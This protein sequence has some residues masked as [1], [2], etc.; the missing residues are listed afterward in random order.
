MISG[1][2]NSSN[3]VRLAR[4]GSASEYAAGL[5]DTGAAILGNAVE[6][7]CSMSRETEHGKEAVEQLK[8]LKNSLMSHI[9]R[10]RA[11]T[12]ANRAGAKDAADS[13]QRGEN[14]K[15]QLQAGHTEVLK[16]TVPVTCRAGAVKELKRVTGAEF[17]QVQAPSFDEMAGVKKFLA[18][19]TAVQGLFTASVMIPGPLSATVKN[20]A[21]ELYTSNSQSQSSVAGS[22]HAGGAALGLLGIGGFS[23][24]SSVAGQ[25]SSST[26]ARYEKSTV[27]ERVVPVLSELQDRLSQ[28]TVVPAS[29]SKL[30]AR[31]SVE[32]SSGKA[33][34]GGLG[35]VK[36]TSI[37]SQ[38]QSS[39]V[40]LDTVLEPNFASHDNRA[41][42]LLE[43]LEYQP[44]HI[45]LPE[46]SIS[47]FK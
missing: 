32:E 5:K 24:D 28:T 11:S 21:K 6:V 14:P 9:E 34:W 45:R 17:A 25:S 10:Q 36:Y 13:L 20:V 4:E 38:V 7:F 35:S 18:D 30:V 43:T 27:D 47:D 40:R 2:I 22:S 44:E 23:S 1:S 42:R 37:G 31:R 8:D 33:S 3:L 12:A 19:L 29:S 39:W 16:D 26:Q 15:Y 41:T 46:S